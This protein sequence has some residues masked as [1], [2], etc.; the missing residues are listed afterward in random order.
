VGERDGTDGINKCGGHQ[1]YFFVFPT[2]AVINRSTVSDADV[3]RFV[4]A[5]TTQLIATFTPAWQTFANVFLAGTDKLLGDRTWRLVLWDEYQAA[6]DVLTLG[7]HFVGEDVPQ[8][9]VFVGPA[10][11]AKLPWEAAAGHELFETL[12]DPWLTRFSLQ[13]DLLWPVEPV[14]PVQGVVLPVDGVPLPDFVLPAYYREGYSGKVDAAGALGHAFT[15][16]P[17]G[18]AAAFRLG[19][20][21]LEAHT[22]YG[23]NCE[24]RT[25]PAPGSRR[26]QRLQKM[27]FETCER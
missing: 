20:N 6:A 15:L 27:G 21:G 17:S 24:T 22:L 14:D 7:R 19:A 23:L 11:R 1:L 2:L 3:Q 26:A 18:Y 4:G 9:H 25:P 12:V 13:G 8:A 10:R 16:A 5:V